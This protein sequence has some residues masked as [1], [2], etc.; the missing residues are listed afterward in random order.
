MNVWNSKFRH[1]VIPKNHRF[2]ECKTC[3]HLKAVIKAKPE[4]MSDKFD[5]EKFVAYREIVSS[6]F[7]ESEFPI[8]VN[9]RV[10]E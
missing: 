4:D 8:S 7:T 10:F 1:V 6:K 5:T 3:S 9:I 2:P